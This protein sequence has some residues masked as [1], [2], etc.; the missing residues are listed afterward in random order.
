MGGTCGKKQDVKKCVRGPN[1]K[2]NVEKMEGAGVFSAHRE[3][4]KLNKDQGDQWKR[5]N[6]RRRFKSSSNKGDK[7]FQKETGSSASSVY[8]AIE[9]RLREGRIGGRNEGP[10][11][12]SLHNEKTWGD[13]GNLGDIRAR[14]PRHC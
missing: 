8:T 7:I 4:Y 2:A 12:R 9:S 13:K 5:G 3:S 6:R 11:F 10:N 1:E 14:Q